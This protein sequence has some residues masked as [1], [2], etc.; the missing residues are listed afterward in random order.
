MKQ[1][2]IGAAI[3]TAL[4]ALPLLFVFARAVAD[5]EVRRKEAPLRGILGDATYELLAS[6]EGSAQNYLGND[7][8]AP[9]F[10]LRDRNGVTWRLRDHRGK[11]VVLNFWTITCG[12]CVEEMP[13]FEALAVSLRERDDVELVTVTADRDWNTVRSVLSPRTPLR[14]LFD[15]ER[16]VITEKFGT[17]LFPETWIID[18][19]GVI[20]L[21][22][23]AARDWSSAVALDLID[24]YR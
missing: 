20:R 22:I 10:E 7:R 19:D 12:P 24:A 6:G 4:V 1:G 8:L 23:D 14:V 11:V 17:R 5:G 16:S 18:K 13:S 2:E 15:P 9:D 21:R 3:L